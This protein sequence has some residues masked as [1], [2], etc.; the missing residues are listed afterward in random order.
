MFELRRGHV[1]QRRVKSVIIVPNF[2]VLED[3]RSCLG[4][5]SE[6]IGDALGFER[7]DETLHRSVVEAVTSVAHADLDVMISQQRLNQPTG[8]LAAL[9]GVV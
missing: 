9:V 2:N 3:D 1:V 8:K 5:C 7:A 6:L 4:P